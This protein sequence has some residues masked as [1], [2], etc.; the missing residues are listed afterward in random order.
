MSRY[1]NGQEPARLWP[2]C[3]PQGPGPLTSTHPYLYLV[4]G[5]LILLLPGLEQ[6]LCIFDHLLQAVFLLLGER[7][8]AKQ[9]GAGGGEREGRVRRGCRGRGNERTKDRGRRETQGAGEAT[10]ADRAR[11]VGARQGRG[12]GR[13]SRG[14]RQEGW[15]P[16][17]G[18]QPL[19]WHSL[20][21]P[22][23]AA[24]S[25]QSPPKSGCHSRPQNH[26]PS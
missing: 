23:T 24:G 25:P 4:N 2:S 6:G 17:P 22:P 18:P 10:Q 8:E 1:K 11:Q 13:Q 12:P 15:L 3:S 5:F 21:N 9:G 7:G 26:T 14:L 20:R 19:P 16:L